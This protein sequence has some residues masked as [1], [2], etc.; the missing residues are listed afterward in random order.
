MCQFIETIRIE[1]GQVYNLSYHTA[2]MNRTRAAFW[3]EAAPIDL[4]GFISPPSLSGI[5]KCR[6]VYDK[7][8]E[9]VGYTPYQMRMVSSLRPVASDTI[10]Y[11]YKSTNREELNDLFARRG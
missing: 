4:S 11:S 9:E 5:W 8:I 10:D 6:I 7:E 2:R 1:D 3:K